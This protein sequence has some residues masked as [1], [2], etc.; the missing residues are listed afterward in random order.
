MAFETAPSASPATDPGHH[1]RLGDARREDPRGIADLLKELRD[2]SQTLLRQEVALAKTELSEKVSQA[3]SDATKIGAGLGVAL[4]GGVVLL[5]A[6][7]NL[8]SAAFE[9]IDNDW[10]SGAIG[11]GLV[12]LVTTIVGYALYKSGLA[13]L[14]HRSLTPEKTL[15]SLKEDKQWLQNKTP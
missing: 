13:A 8:V 11:Y 14:K 15:A 7:A 9:F 6:L 4:L 2:E 3:T 5:I 10:I 1:D 12:G